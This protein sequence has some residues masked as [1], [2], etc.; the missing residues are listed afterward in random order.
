MKGGLLLD[1]VVRQ[2]TSIL[3][4]LSGENET[5]LVGRNTFLVLDLGLDVIDSVRGLDLESDGLARESLDED[6]H[7]STKTKDE[8][9]SALL[10]D[11]VIGK[12]S[13]V[14]KLLS[15]EDQ[16]LLIR[17]DTL[18]ILDLGLDVVNGIRRLDL[19][20][21]S[22]ASQRL[23]EDLHTATK[24]EDQVEGG[25]FLNIVIRKSAAVLELLAS[26]DQALLVGR[27]TVNR[28]YQISD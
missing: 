9:E 18:L 7:S 3:K 28:G 4:L 16:A 11:V 27:D 15:G 26:E 13:S 23:D 12:G 8:M 22:L 6:L 14:L 1:I 19:E 2:S 17:G 24:T 10:L 21:D 20:G 5:L 25:L